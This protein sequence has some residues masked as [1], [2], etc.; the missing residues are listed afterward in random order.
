MLYSFDE[1]ER[2]LVFDE[3]F[4][5][6]DDEVEVEVVGVLIICMRILTKCNQSFKNFVS[7][8]FDEVQ[9]EV[10]EQI[11]DEIEQQTHD[12]VEVE[13]E[14]DQMFDEHE[15][16]VDLDSLLFVIRQ[17]VHIE[18]KL[19]PE[20]QLQQQQLI[21]SLIRYTH[22]QILEHLKSQKQHKNIYNSK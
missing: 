18:S 5:V 11:I 21:E 17:I 3:L 13:H 16:M 19:Q 2:L 4:V 12:E 8:V 14:H 20:E 22:S 10:V 7:L 6:C 1:L 15:E 9:V